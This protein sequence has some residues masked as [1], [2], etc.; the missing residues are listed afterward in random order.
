[1][2]KDVITLTP[3]MP[4]VDTILAGLF[5]GGPDLGVST[6]AQGPVVQ[7]CAPDGHPLVSIEAPQLVH[8]PG[9]AGRLLGSHAPLLQGP[10]WWTEARATTAVPEAARLAGSFAG[11]V[12]SVLG[13]AV[14]PPEAA[15]TDVVPLTT[16]TTALPAPDT[17]SAPALDIV[18]DQAVVV[19]QDRPFV[20]MTTWLTE[21]VRTAAETDRAFQLLTPPHTRLTLP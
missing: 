10:F 3:D 8:V 19:M 7:L 17:T 15:H 21:A 5:A 16:D 11:R 18:T 6:V 2:T 9:E 20:A 4:S 1:M 14:W 13:G 12:A